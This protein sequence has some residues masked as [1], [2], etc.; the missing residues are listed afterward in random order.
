MFCLLYNKDL[1][2]KVSS[3]NSLVSEVLQAF[4]YLAFIEA[5]IKL[6]D[7]PERI[8]LD[9][10]EMKEAVAQL[11]NKYTI[12]DIELVANNKKKNRIFCLFYK[13]YKDYLCSAKFLDIHKNLQY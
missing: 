13:S 4:C 9:S 3:R 10:K 12:S 6:N 8:I 2:L 7:L 11:L 1:F 5:K